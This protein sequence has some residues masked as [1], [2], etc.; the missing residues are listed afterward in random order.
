MAYIVLHDKLREF[1]FEFMVH[2]NHMYI[3]GINIMVRK[4]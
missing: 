3:I 1:K 4:S 2:F